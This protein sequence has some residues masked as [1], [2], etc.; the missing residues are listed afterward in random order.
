[1]ITI[2][3]PSRSQRYVIRNDAIL[4]VIIDV[5]NDENV[6]SVIIE[7]VGP[8]KLWSVKDPG[9]MTQ[10]CQEYLKIIN[11]PDADDFVNQESELPILPKKDRKGSGRFNVI[12]A[13]G[14]TN[15]NPDDG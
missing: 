13:T 6:L 11:D 5:K 2:E 14:R 4:G 7:G 10:T 15:K 12:G 8:V 3:T 1:M 9:T